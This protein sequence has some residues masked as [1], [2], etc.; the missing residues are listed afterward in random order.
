MHHRGDSV[1][2]MLCNNQVNDDNTAK[3]Q[4]QQSLEDVAHFADV[5]Q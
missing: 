1:M 5:E 4:R 2:V 3:S